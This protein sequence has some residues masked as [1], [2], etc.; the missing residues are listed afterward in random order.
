ML[1]IWIFKKKKKC[2]KRIKPQ[3]PL[4]AVL[5]ESSLYDL[6]FYKSIFYRLVFNYII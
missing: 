6:K 3:A 1:K 4:F 5:W 2:S